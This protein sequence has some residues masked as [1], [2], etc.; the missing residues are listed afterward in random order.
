M[1]VKG[2]GTLFL[3]GTP[4]GNM[5]DITLRALETLKKVDLIA[6]EDT[7]RT[8]KILAHYSIQKPLTS[9]Y[10]HN[11]KSK[12]P[13]LMSELRQGKRIALVSDAGMPGISDPGLDLVRECISQGIEITVIPGPSALLTGL[14]AS[15]LDTAGFVYTGFVPR[16]KKEKHA[17]LQSLSQETRTIIL[18][19]S[20][21]RLV[22]TLRDIQA[23]WG[24]RP[25]CVARELTKI[26]EEYRRGTVGDIIAAFTAKEVKGEITLIIGGK[27]NMPGIPP[28]WGEVEETLL[29]FEKKG[30]TRKEAVRET[31]KTLGI[32]K[33][34]LYNRVMK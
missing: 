17:F 16:G 2:S 15:G 29:E 25:C 1:E 8:Q 9:Y 3:V 28:S 12:G 24:N 27:E 20:P 32:S 14:V 4:I 5:G 23:A 19:E 30:L 22:D 21:H 18:F 6:A 10:E 13:L 34:E 11:K 26:H 33:R 7:R 31:A